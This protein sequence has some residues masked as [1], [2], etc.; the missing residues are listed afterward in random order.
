MIKEPPDGCIEIPGFIIV[1]SE[2]KAWLTKD[3]NV[4]DDFKQRGVWETEKEVE[5]AIDKFFD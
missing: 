3:G 1:V 2:E 5:D 4:T